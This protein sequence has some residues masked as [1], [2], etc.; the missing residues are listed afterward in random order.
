MNNL[1]TLKETA[2]LLS[3][4]AYNVRAC[5]DGAESVVADAILNHIEAAER[6]I[7]DEIRRIE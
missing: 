7:E 3:D 1:Q 4:S 5:W 6:L 2:G